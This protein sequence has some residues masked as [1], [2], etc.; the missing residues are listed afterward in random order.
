MIGSNLNRTARFGVRAALLATSLLAATPALAQLTTSTI[1]GHVTTSAAPSPGAAVTARNVDTNAITQAT[2]GPDGSY[3]LTGLRPGTYDITTG[4]AAAQRVTIGAGATATLDIDTAAPA[5]APAPAPGVA[6]APPGTIVVTG[7]R[8]V[9]TKTSE[10]ATNISRDFLQKRNND[11]V[12]LKRIQYG[13]AD[14]KS[15]V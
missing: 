13:A 6:A 12:K 5:P 10:V 9:E 11:K 4:T 7:R 15:V 14:R 8:L 1:R 2:T 3:S